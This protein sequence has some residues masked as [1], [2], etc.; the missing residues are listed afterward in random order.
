MRIILKKGRSLIRSIFCIG[1]CGRGRRFCR[2]RTNFIFILISWFIFFLLCVLK[3]YIDSDFQLFH[4]HV[5]MTTMKPDHVLCILV[6]FRDRNEELKIF[7]PHITNF[8][9]EQHVRHKI[10]VL[11][12]TDS[13]RFNR[14]ALIN[15]GWYEADRVG[16]DYMVMHDVDLLPL[17]E[18]LNYSFPDVGIVRHISSPEYHPQYNYSKF[19]GGILMLTLYDYKLVNGMSNK[20]WGWGLED[21]EFY[22]RLRDGNL[23]TMLERPTN[24]TTNRRN[25]FRHIHDGRLK[26]RDRLVIGNQKAM[27]RRRDRVSGLDSVRYRI[28]SRSLLPIKDVGPP[29][30]SV[31]NIELYCDMNWTPYC[32]FPDSLPRDVQQRN[33]YVKKQQ[34]LI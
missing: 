32:V 16:C 9:N 22:L 5:P 27:S 14:A 26:R 15:V 29:F 12:Q 7:A 17:N 30:M 3:N 10:I 34:N 25:T 19:I 1:K 11:N 4:W 21:D 2:W 28:V 8:L 6:P 18:E 23:T 24:L 13:L 31:L 33:A 20:Y